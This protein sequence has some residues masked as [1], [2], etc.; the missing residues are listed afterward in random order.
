MPFQQDVAFAGEVGQ[1]Y[2]RYH[3]T[4]RSQTGQ[5][6]A[7]LFEQSGRLVA[8]VSFP[9]GLK[10]EDVT[11]AYVGELN[12]HAAEHGFAGNLKIIYVES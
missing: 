8:H 5:V 10:P 1:T 3:S 11:D 2:G 9:S 6:L 4:F 7:Q 12:R